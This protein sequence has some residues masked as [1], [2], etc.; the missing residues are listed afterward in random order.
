MANHFKMYNSKIHTDNDRNNINSIFPEENN[1]LNSHH[2]FPSKRK[3]YPHEKHLNVFK[4]VF[5][6]SY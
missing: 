5:E 2:F 3:L 6:F 1:V 4:F